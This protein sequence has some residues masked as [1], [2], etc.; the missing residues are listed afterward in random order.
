MQPFA[1]S[2]LNT[3]GRKKTPL[4]RRHKWVKYGSIDEQV[5]GI[6]RRDY[7]S[8]DEREESDSLN[9]NNRAQVKGDVD[10]TLGD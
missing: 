3:K 5:G 9:G 8:D 1:C 6:Y 10:Y 7:S 4:D 2:L